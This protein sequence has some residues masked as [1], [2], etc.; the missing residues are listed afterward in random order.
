MN[1][2]SSLFTALCV[3]AALIVTSSALAADG[4]WMKRAQEG[5]DIW[6]TFQTS[7]GDIVVKLFPKDA[8]KTVVNFVGLAAGEKSWKHPGT[9]VS[10]TEPLYRGIVFH[11]VIPGF[12]IQGGDPLGTGRGDPGYRFEDEFQSGRKFDKDGLLAMANAG[13]GTNGSQFFITTSRPD[14][15]NGRHTIFGEVVAGY[16]VAVKIS[17]VPR[18]GQ[19][20]PRTPVTLKKVELSE[21]PPKGV[22]ADKAVAPKAKPA[23]AATP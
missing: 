17:Q 22:P 11:R 21:K 2:R 4:K 8:P 16:D 5:K 7:E 15:L 13:P 12:M 10:S 3:S 6:A 19:D 9:G 23:P 14:Y 20:R 1:S 18:D